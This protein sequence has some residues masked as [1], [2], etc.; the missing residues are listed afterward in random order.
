MKLRR[1]LPGDIPF[2]Y[3][4]EK[5]YIEEL[6]NDQ[7]IKWQDNIERHLEQW[8]NILPQTTIA[9]LQGTR[10]GYLFWE[11][12]GTKALI[13]SVNVAVE[14]RRKGVGLALLERFESEA[15]LAGCSVAELG[16]VTHNPARYLYEKCG[17]QPAGI[18]GRYFLMNKRLRTPGFKCFD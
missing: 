6:E 7:L 18:E 14:C 3:R 5:Q 4:L 16:F 13:A 1:G 8:I 17:Y 12:E 9:Q 10:A 15:L 11:R 2:I